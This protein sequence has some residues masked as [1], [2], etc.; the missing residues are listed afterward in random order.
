[1]FKKI[2]SALAIAS[3][4]SGCFASSLSAQVVVNEIMFHPQHADDSQEPIVEEFIELL[5]TD[6]VN[7]INLTGWRFSK[8]VDF[9]FG[10]FILP[11]G[12]F[13][14][15][16]ADA[17]AF[18]TKYPTVT[19]PIVGPW[20]GRLSNGG[21]RIRLLNALGEEVDDITYFDEGD[22]AVRR[23]G[24]RDAGHTGWI[25]KND[26]DG[27]G[28]S[29]ELI[30]P[31]MPNQHGQNWHAST[32]TGGSPGA[33]NSVAAPN[34]APIIRNVRHTPAVPLPTDQVVVT[35]TLVDEL[36]PG[37]SAIL[38]HRVSTLAPGS[39]SAV[40]MVDLGDNEFGGILPA[41][42]NGSVVEFFVESS[43]GT[44]TRRWPG[45]TDEAGGQKANLLYQVD[46]GN[47]TGSQGDYRLILSVPEAQ[48]FTSRNFNRRSDAQMNT[49]FV[50]LRGNDEDIRYQAGLRRRGAGSRSRQPLTLRLNLPGDQPWRGD[51]AL[52][53][54]SQYPPLQILG[55]KIF[56]AAGIV[57]PDARPV[58]LRINGE[59][60][61]T[62]GGGQLWHLCA[63][64]AAHW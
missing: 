59:L 43:D 56:T 11:A 37:N 15:I 62:P 35:A 61:N 41:Q 1:M 36:A 52:N 49:T 12:G 51:T 47:Y 44:H 7:A 48:E 58:Q 34:I 46:D 4:A 40:Q 18:S 26:A 20:T 6:A 22:W 32:V 2:V 19:T 42:S 60:Q 14:I 39:F 13:V 31:A 55:Q 33:L 50:S 38:Y 30:N 45:P 9:T 54:N 5:N 63:H 17:T 25:W 10:N 8:G 23:E 64:G 3:I 57:A 27:A 29:L 28:S 53:L 16:A 21:E 24:P